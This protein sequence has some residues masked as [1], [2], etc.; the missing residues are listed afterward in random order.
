MK[1]IMWHPLLLV[2]LLLIIPTSVLAQLFDSSSITCVS[3]AKNAEKYKSLITLIE[4]QSDFNKSKEF[5]EDLLTQSKNDADNGDIYGMIT[6]GSNKVFSVILD[7]YDTNYSE[8]RLPDTVKNELIEAMIYSY[9]AAIPETTAKTA[10]LKNI[11]RLEKMRLNYAG[12]EI[13]LEWIT[14]AKKSAI[15][16]DES[17]KNAVGFSH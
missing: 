2:M 7:L 5:Q 16:W 6:Y 13:P 9:M 11:H 15:A 8:K 1:R 10:A 3:Y 17:C 14:Q 12:Y 4:S